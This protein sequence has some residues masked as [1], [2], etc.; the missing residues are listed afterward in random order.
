MIGQE[1]KAE[2]GL[3]GILPFVSGLLLVLLMLVQFNISA[4]ENIFPFL[5]LIAIYYW[6][7]FKPKLMP[8]SIV[9]LLGLLQDILSGGPLGMTALLLILVR[10]FV[11]SQ[12]RRFLEREFLFSWL[13]FIFVS[14]AYGA[15]VWLVASVYLKETQNIWNA[16]G[17][18]TLTIMIFPA[19]V[20][21]LGW[22]RRLLVA[23]SR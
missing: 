15:L 12:G 14:L 1:T 20:W 23:E 9:F 10:V 8:V 5:S 3:R 6:S 13:V 17:Q 16:M 4:I 11:L 7:I 19:I 21:P 18:S 2:K 22:L